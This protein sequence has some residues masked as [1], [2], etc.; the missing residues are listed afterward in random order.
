MNDELFQEEVMATNQVNKPP[1]FDIEYENCQERSS[2][3][4]DDH[5]KDFGLDSTLSISLAGDHFITNTHERY[6]MCNRAMSHCGGY[7]HKLNSGGAYKGCA[8][9]SQCNKEEEHDHIDS[10]MMD[11][12]RWQFND[13]ESNLNL[14]N[15]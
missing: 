9:F 14:K 7:N 13:A 3:G 4:E 5:D 2:C 1:R 15:R 12:E 6:K 11:F 8:A 10:E